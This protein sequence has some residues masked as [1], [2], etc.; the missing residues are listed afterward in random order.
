MSASGAVLELGARS[1]GALD[2]AG[3]ALAS[4]GL[5][6]S[7]LPVVVLFA[8]LLAGLL[9]A[10][11]YARKRKWPDAALVLVAALALWALLSAPR[12]PGAAG[13]EVA[14]A[15][16]NRGYPDAMTRAL[17]AVPGARSI[18]LDGHGLH[19]AQWRDLPARPLRW[20]EPEVDLL[21]LESPRALPLG[22]QFT[23]TA[24]RTRP[25]AGWRLQLLAENGEILAESGKEPSGA[26][27]RLTV[28]WLPPL[29]ETLTLKARLLDGA[30]KTIAEGPVPLRVEAPI[31]L[32]VEGRFGAPSFDTRVLNQLLTDSNAIAD[33]QTT[34]GKGL[35]RS[36][37]A[38]AALSE[39]HARFI[40]AAWFESASVPAR[41]AL[42]AQTAQGV[43]LI[44]LAG[45]AAD[46]GVWQRE[47]GLRLVPQSATTEKEDA[48]QF[49]SGTTQLALAPAALNPAE[50]AGAPWTVLAR[51]AKGKPW[52]WQRDW[53]GGRV[54][55]LGVG[56]WH[57]YAITAPAALGH[58]WQG[59]LDQAAIGSA[60][61]LAWLQPAAMPVAGLRTEICAQGASPGGALE[62]EGQASVNWQPRADKADAVCAAFWPARSGWQALR[63]GDNVHRVYVHAANDWPAW[64]RALRHDATAAYAARSPAATNAAAT[65]PAYPAWPFALLFTLAMLTL[66]FRERR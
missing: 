7:G 27:A 34:L 22:R 61:K 57:R 56:D 1:S 18:V 26:P 37:T 43:P 62:I 9:S 64:Q 47:L 31:P 5:P 10:A 58:W 40:D 3:S 35:A 16:E 49:G 6:A 32:Q 52:L 54:V 8:G 51:D 44:V 13:G 14:L 38:R 48:R 50:Q 60:R 66:W 4:W 53:K 41:A 15:T 29:A 24:H 11:M 36:E 45:N 19:A 39:V 55:W 17:L 21:R 65:G 12:G 59:L 20:T 33:W 46:A 2:L 30:G 63:S 25:A 28:Q 23:L 42:L